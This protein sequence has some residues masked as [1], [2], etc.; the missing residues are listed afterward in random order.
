MVHVYNFFFSY[1]IGCPVAVFNTVKRDEI[2]DVVIIDCDRNHVE[3][4]Y[5]D[6]SDMPSDIVN[7]LKRNLSNSSDLRGRKKR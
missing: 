2:G 4:P 7:Y 3:N 1:C 6:M 5:N